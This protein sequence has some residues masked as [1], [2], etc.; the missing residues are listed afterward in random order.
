MGWQHRQ[1]D[2]R[3]GKKLWVRGVTWQ[4]EGQSNFL[5]FVTWN[6]QGICDRNCRPRRHGGLSLCL[7]Q[8]FI[9]PIWGWCKQEIFLLIIS[10][11]GLKKKMYDWGTSTLTCAESHQ[12]QH[13]DVM[14]CRAHIRDW[15]A[16]GVIGNSSIV[17]PTELFYIFHHFGVIKV[18]SAHYFLFQS[19]F[20]PHDMPAV[21]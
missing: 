17:H 10:V 6:L 1:P 15:T 13:R 7:R 4:E 19:Y 18:T 11:C 3:K 20:R 8:I 16:S 5:C 9:S 14:Q 21:C 2:N 12:S